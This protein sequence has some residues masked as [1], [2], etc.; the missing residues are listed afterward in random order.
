MNEGNILGSRSLLSAIY[1]YLASLV[2][3][4]NALLV[5][6]ET[7][8]TITTNGAE[9]DIYINNAPAALWAPKEIFIDTTAQ[10][11]GKTIKVRVY[12]RIKIGGNFIKFVEET[13]ADLQDPLGVN[14]GLKE[15]RFGLQITIENTAGVNTAYDWELKYKV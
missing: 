7:G 11:I 13:Y 1:A 4:M 10:G 2:A 3:A 8:G 15:N 14:I 5:L 12:Y 6:T 9:Q